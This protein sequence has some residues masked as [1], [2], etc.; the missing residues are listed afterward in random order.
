MS[1]HSGLI[2]GSAPAIAILLESRLPS[3]HLLLHSAVSLSLLAAKFPSAACSFAAAAA[4]PR[5]VVVAA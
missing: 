4:A 1:G 2:E 5:V 3:R